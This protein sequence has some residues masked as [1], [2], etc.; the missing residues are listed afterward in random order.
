MH[1]V[2]LG[3]GTGQATLLRGLREYPCDVTAIV[4]RLRAAAPAAVAGQGAA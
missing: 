3:S 1:V 4:G 2:T